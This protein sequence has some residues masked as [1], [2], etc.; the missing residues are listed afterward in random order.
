MKI[1]LL[2]NN[3]KI[4]SKRLGRGHGSGRGKTSGKGT[5]GQKARS[6]HNIPRRFEG[7]QSTLIQRMPK[8]GGFK[9][10]N[11]KPEIVN[12]RDIDKKYSDGDNVNIESLKKK[13][14]ISKD[15]KNVK[16]LG[17]GKLTK[18][19]TFDKLMMSKSV[20]ELIK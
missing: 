20:K 17:T 10:R 2:K 7:G 9:S 6:G 18:K 1:H 4:T 19:I 3:N 16:I 11:I 8:V 12:I 15:A 5:K 13:N 14:L